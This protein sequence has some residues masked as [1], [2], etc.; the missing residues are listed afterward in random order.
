MNDTTAFNVFNNVHV[1][2]ESSHY[3][4]DQES[5]QL[6]RAQWLAVEIQYLAPLSSAIAL[7]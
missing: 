1:D 5:E 6:Q 2:Q 3:K 7:L 4:T